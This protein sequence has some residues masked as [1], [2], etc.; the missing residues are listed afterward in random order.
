M[1]NFHNEGDPCLVPSNCPCKF[2]DM[3]MSF[4]TASQLN[5]ISTVALVIAKQPHRI[6][7]LDTYGYSALH[8]A[9]Q[10]NNIAIVN[11]LLS[12]GAHP[13]GIGT[14]TSRCGATPLHRAGD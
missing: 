14:N 13:D 7:M 5:N 1:S 2:F 12:H 4:W 3:K 11:M 8:Y 6:N 9:A 10:A